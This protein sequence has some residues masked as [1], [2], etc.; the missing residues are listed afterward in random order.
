MDAIAATSV[1]YVGSC[2]A[3]DMV[4]F[5]GPESVPPQFKNR[6]FYHHNAQVTLMRTTVGECAQIGKWIGQKLNACNG[7]VRFLLPLKGVSALDIVEGPFHDPTANFALFDALKD[8]VK[9]TDERRLVE[10]DY[11]INDPEFALASISAFREIFVNQEN[12]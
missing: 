6:L 8:T 10:I 12:K 11:H 7:P 3:L 9:Q 4:N 1:P 5:W 2:G